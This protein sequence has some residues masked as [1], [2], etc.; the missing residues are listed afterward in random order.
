MK[1]RLLVT[2]SL[3]SFTFLCLGA[4]T[5][6]GIR[7]TGRQIKRSVRTLSTFVC[8]TISS[9]CV[10][11]YHLAGQLFTTVDSH[12]LYRNFCYI[13]GQLVL[14]E[15]VSTWSISLWRGISCTRKNLNL[16]I[17]KS[18]VSHFQFAAIDFWR[19]SSIVSVLSSAKWEIQQ[20]DWLGDSSVIFLFSL[21]P[22]IRFPVY[23]PD[24]KGFVL[25]LLFCVIPN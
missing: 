11:S 20:N 14:Y 21:M 22:P 7:L 13:L 2:G 10:I 18:S 4:L 16:P 1:E 9:Y 23:R 5:A 3:C 8:F 6:W 15:H 25:M 12:L 19:I 24:I 17:V